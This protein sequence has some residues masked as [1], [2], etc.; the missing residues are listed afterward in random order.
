MTKLT[1]TSGSVAKLETL[2]TSV[3]AGYG[4]N[5]F[6]SVCTEDKLS[7]TGAG[8]IDGE[9]KSFNMTVWVE[10]NTDQLKVT[11]WVADDAGHLTLP[12]TVQ[13]FLSWITE[14]LV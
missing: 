1:V 3:A 13:A 10:E 14:G 2:V 9:L 6:Y 12:G 8:V 11:T 4:F 7:M 5:N